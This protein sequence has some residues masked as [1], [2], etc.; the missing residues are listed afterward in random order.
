MILLRADQAQVEWNS[1]KKHWQ[2]VITV[3]AEVIKRP[4]PKQPRDASDATLQSLAVETAKD[5]GYEVD[6][7]RVSVAR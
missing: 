7:A 3:G 5:E 6:P 2:V 4:I 1:E